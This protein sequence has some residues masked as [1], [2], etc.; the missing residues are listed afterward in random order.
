[1]ARASR[2]RRA[3]IAGGTTPVRAAGRYLLL[4]LVAALVLFPIWAVLL[5]AL[6]SGPDSLDHPRSLL[7]VDLTLDTI[8]AA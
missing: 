3:G 4:A 1:M 5:Q 7:P 6:K 2:R 8:R